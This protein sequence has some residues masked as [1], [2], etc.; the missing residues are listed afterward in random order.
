MEQFHEHCYDEWWHVTK[1][2]YD[3]ANKYYDIY[4][5]LLKK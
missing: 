4:I 2:D 3:K 1:V 5:N